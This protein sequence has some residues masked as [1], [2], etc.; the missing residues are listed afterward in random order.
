MQKIDFFLKVKGGFSRWP[1]LSAK[2][3]LLDAL[4][5]L[6]TLS[7][8]SDFIFEMIHGFIT[9]LDDYNEHEAPGNPVVF[10]NV[11]RL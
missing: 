10:L 5:V 1:F 9:I 2:V 4:C 7:M 3:Y 8:L 11:P 6:G